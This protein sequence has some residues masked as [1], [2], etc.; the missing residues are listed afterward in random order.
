MLEE[1]RNAIQEKHALEAADERAGCHVHFFKHQRKEKTRTEGK[2]DIVD[3][4]GNLEL[5]WLSVP[6]ANC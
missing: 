3:L 4:E 1:K 5:E 2:V 6:S